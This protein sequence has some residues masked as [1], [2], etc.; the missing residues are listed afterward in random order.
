M[1]ITKDM[2]IVE[3]VQT[4]PDTVEVLMNRHRHA[5]RGAQRDDRREICGTVK[6]ILAKE[7]HSWIFP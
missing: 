7:P 1:A 5:H 3:I 6:Y 2:S 4:Y